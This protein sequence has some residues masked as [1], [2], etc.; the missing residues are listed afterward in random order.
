[1]EGW[2]QGQC[3]SPDIVLIGGDVLEGDRQDEDTSGYEAQFRRIRAKSS[4]YGA[5]RK[6]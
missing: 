2:F 5:P 6:P 1:M 4:V 3:A